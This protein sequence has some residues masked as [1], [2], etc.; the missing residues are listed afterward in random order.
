M[1][2]ILALAALGLGLYFATKKDD[3]K[4][5]DSKDP[6]KGM[7]ADTPK[8][9]AGLLGVDPVYNFQYVVP[10]KNTKFE[11]LARDSYYVESRDMDDGGAIAVVTSRTA[12]GPTIEA[13]STLLMKEYFKAA[14]PLTIITDWRNVDDAEAGRPLPDKMKFFFVVRSKARPYAEP[15]SMFAVFNTSD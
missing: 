13:Q 3:P 9:P 8:P 10:G 7:G 11:A 2:E 5:V 1:I 15:G 12:T 14:D 4:S 6:D